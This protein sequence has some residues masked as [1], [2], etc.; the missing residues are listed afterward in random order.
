V[1]G[2]K[3][4]VARQHRTDGRVVTNSAVAVRVEDATA[5]RR[6]VR[7][8]RVAARRHD[9]TVGRELTAAIFWRWASR[10]NGRP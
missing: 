2:R 5:R 7:R 3:E 9:I 4:G 6:R 8:S 10:V 1:S